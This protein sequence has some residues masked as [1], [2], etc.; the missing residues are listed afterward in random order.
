MPIQA[1]KLRRLVVFQTRGAQEPDSFRN[2]QDVWVDDFE[3]RVEFQALGSAE[4]HTGWKRY[5]ETT[6]RLHM[7]FRQ[8]VDSAK[9]RVLIVD[10]RFSPVSTK[11]F[12]I[13]PPLDPDGRMR[14]MFVELVEVEGTS[15]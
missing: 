7:R 13:K 5:A 3:D 10:Q 15:D 9:H 12:D 14:E 2:P 11:K 8:D 1:G 6:A 4:F